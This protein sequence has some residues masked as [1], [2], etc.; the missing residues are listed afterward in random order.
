MACFSNVFVNLHSDTIAVEKKQWV[1]LIPLY[2]IAD[3]WP[4]EPY[5][6][7]FPIEDEVTP[8]LILAI[9]FS[10]FFSKTH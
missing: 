7:S 3:K 1:D 6:F 9:F 5:Y 4:V 10:S 2:I 8:F